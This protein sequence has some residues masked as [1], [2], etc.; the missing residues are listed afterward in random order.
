MS[1][2]LDFDDV[3]PYMQDEIGMNRERKER[4]KNSW[5]MN[6][7]QHDEY[8]EDEDEEEEE[9]EETEE[10]FE[11]CVDCLNLFWPDDLEDDRCQSCLIEH[12]SKDDED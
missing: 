11:F 2:H 8:F 4:R 7:P 6:D 9:D 3:D 5:K 10:D 12:L 1:L